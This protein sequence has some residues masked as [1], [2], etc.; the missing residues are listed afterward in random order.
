[1]PRTFHHDFYPSSHNRVTTPEAEL[2]VREIEDAGL[3][4]VLQTPGATFGSWGILETLLRP[5]EQAPFVF[6]E[7]LGRA[8]EVKVALSG[9]FGRFVA[10]AYLH[11][12]FQL[13]FFAHVAYPTMILDNRHRIQID[14]LQPRGDLPDWVAC[15][16][17]STTSLPNLAVVEAKGSH[18]LSG[19]DEALQR[20]WK[21][22]CRIDVLANG[23]RLPVNRFAIATRWGMAS[24]GPLEPCISV[25][26]PIDKGDPIK[27]E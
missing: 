13:S 5:G 21:Q 20:A 22:A 12:Y 14:K 6:R 15:A 4:E 27:R 24:G 26:D 2:T 1:M 17:P 23:N 8:R 9:L 3:L 10:R 18:A 7:P 11:K 16:T 25:R 19:P